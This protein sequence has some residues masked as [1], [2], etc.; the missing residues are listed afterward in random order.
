MAFMMPVVKND[1]DIY[2]SQRSRRASESADKGSIGGRVRKVSESRS[3]G[4]VL[5][6]R[7]A[8]T[9]SPH[10]S[11]PAMRSLSYCR[12][13]PSRASLRVYESQRGSGSP[14][15]KNRD[16]EKFHS[17]LVEK[18]RRAFGRSESRN[19]ERSS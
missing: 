11:A 17:R 10:R 4:P 16:S 18:L 13:P 1:W 9:L 12:V 3:E 2:N 6:P 15:G 5:S 8:A 19:D 14:T 7:T